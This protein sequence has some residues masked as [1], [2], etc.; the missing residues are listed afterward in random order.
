MFRT[1]A[2][3]LS[4][5]SFKLNLKLFGT[6]VK[7]GVSSFI[8]QMA[9]VIVALVSNMALAKYGLLSKYGADIP[10][11][12][13]GICLKVFGIVVNVIVDIVLVAQPILGFNYGA[14]R[15]DRVK[16]T[17]YLVLKFAIAISLFFTI[18]V[19]IWPELI[20][21]IFGSS[22]DLY[23]EFA[24]KTF[25]I[26]LS[27]LVF[28]SI[29]KMI[30]IFFQSVGEPIKATAV[31]L[32]RDIIFFVPLALILPNYL[33]ITGALL[34]VPF[35]DLLGGVV[36]AIL[37][38]VFLKKIGN[39]TVEESEDTV[40]KKSRPGVVIT[41]EREHGS[42][43]KYIGELVAK[44]LNIPYYYKEM[45]SLAAKESGLDKEFISKINSA[46]DIMHDLY[47]TTSPVKYAIEAQ[48]KII[49]KIAM[50]GS[51]VIVVRAADHILRDN[52]K[53]VRVFIY[54]SLEYKTKKIQEMYGDS[55][56]EAIKNIKKS[57]KNRA[58][59][60]KMILG[61]VWRDYGNY[62]IL[63]DSSIGSFKTADIILIM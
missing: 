63:I 6:V 16:E 19:E 2:F 18:I 22:S 3:K 46:N 26:F 42:A 9:I 32:S 51:C 12:A 60:Y 38:V 27:L 30:S 15:Y 23:M 53:L 57:N 40:I 50:E 52:S 43:G 20:I 31:S 54:A 58:A 14:K 13:I 1:K 62:N 21:N 36:T 37:T 39:E 25:R 35:A 41:I 56:K 8:T 45:T 11:A 4:K 34:A 33:G 44:K 17:F 61:N 5:N 49:K 29:I 47:L 55:E 24:I 10:I 48:E 7:L 59:Y 28:S